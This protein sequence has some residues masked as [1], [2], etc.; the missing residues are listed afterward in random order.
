MSQYSNKV[1]CIRDEENKSPEQLA[2]DQHHEASF[3]KH[4]PASV[5]PL[6]QRHMM[7]SRYHVRQVHSLRGNA[8]D[9]NRVQNA[10]C[11]PAS[12]PPNQPVP[13]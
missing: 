4:G 7:C 6:E 3:M 9:D 8:G 1:V 12:H 10:V 13:Y 11:L 2:D 5:L